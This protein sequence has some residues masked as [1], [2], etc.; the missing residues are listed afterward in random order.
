MRMLPL[1]LLCMPL[2]AQTLIDRQMLPY[3]NDKANKL[4]E[5]QRYEDALKIY[6]DLYGKDTKNGA[7]AYNMGN[8]YAAM[9]EMEKAQ[10]FYSKAIES[11]NEEA[12]LRAQFNLGN[13]QMGAKKINEAVDQYVDYLHDR[14]GDIDAKRNL[15][16]ALRALEQQEQQQEQDDK[17]ENKDQ[18]ENKDEQQ[19]QQQQQSE[20]NEDQEKDEQEQQQQQQK[21]KE[22]EQ[23]QQGQPQE[24]DQNQEGEEKKQPQEAQDTLDEKRKEQLLKALKEQ[25]MEQQKEYQKRKVGKVRKRAK[26][27]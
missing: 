10:D 24:Q 1:F 14:P 6:Q 5:E 2:A 19:Q 20:Q 8:A 12:R 25:E 15:E 18:E 7:L 4:F 23:N 9:G 26:D 21:D 22:E 3:T 27:W 13:L 11:D 17:D 16:L